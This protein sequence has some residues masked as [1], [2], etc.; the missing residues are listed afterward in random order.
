[1]AKVDL[2][3][4]FKEFLK[5][6]NSTGVKYLVLGGYSVIHYGYERST[7]DLDIWTSG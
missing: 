2:H 4:D 5:L 3:P 1:M 7:A 6:L